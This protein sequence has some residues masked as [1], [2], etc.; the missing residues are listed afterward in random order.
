MPCGLIIN[1]LVSNAL[2]H[3]FPEP[4]PVEPGQRNGKANAIRIDL[5]PEDKDRVRLVVGDNGVGLPQDLD[6]AA[7]DS[8]GLRLVYTL[9]NQLDGTVEMRNNDGAEFKLTFTIS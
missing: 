4:V 3:A 9:I 1:E 6:L 8:L 2:K 7:V 5:A